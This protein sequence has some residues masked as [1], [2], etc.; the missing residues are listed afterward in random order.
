MLGVLLTDMPRHTAF[1]CCVAM[2]ALGCVLA[3]ALHN[4]V[5]HKSANQSAA[6]ELGSLLGSSNDADADDE[7]KTSQ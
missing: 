7:E 1:A 2:L 4:I 3:S 5:T 6:M